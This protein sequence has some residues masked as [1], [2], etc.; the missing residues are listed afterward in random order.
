M[1]PQDAPRSH[2]RVPLRIVRV[3]AAIRRRRRVGFDRPSTIIMDDICIVSGRMSSS[4]A[5]PP[6]GGRCL[7]RRPGRDITRLP[8]ATF[9]DSP[10]PACSFVVSTTKQ[11]RRSLPSTHH[12]AGRHDSEDDEPPQTNQKIMTFQIL[13]LMNILDHKSHL[14]GNVNQSTYCD[15]SEDK[16]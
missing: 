14:K 12:I 16:V 4:P 11:R 9:V 2:F 8:A 13:D 5:W 10:S 15:I 3:I 7:I 6:G 1:W